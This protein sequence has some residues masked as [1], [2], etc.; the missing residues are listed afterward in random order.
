ML[1]F[2]VIPFISREKL[3]HAAG[4]FDGEGTSR[5]KTSTIYECVDLIIRMSDSES[6]EKFWKATCFR[7]RIITPYKLPSGTLMYGCAAMNY[8]DFQFVFCLLWPWLG[9]IKK[10]QIKRV[11]EKYMIH[12]KL[13]MESINV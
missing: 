4:L 3:A 2:S 6:I 12:H 8:E 10:N 5:F 7:T 9:R 11:L 13:R 1:K